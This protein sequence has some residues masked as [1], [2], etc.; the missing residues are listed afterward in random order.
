MWQGPYEMIM[1]E[2]PRY[3][4]KGIGGRRTR[5]A[6]HVRRLL[7]FYM[8]EGAEDSKGDSNDENQN[9][10]EHHARN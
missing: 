4:L 2:H 3:Q 9:R 8:R 5:R 7:R 6:V 1:E 10:A